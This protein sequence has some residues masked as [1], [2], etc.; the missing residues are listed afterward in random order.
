M[1]RPARDK[2][3]ELSVM[4]AQATPGARSR[5]RPPWPPPSRRVQDKLRH[6]D[7]ESGIFTARVGVASVQDLLE[8]SDGAPPMPHE[9]AMELLA[10]IAYPH[11]EG[12]TCDPCREFKK[13]QR[14]VEF[15]HTQVEQLVRPSQ[16]DVEEQAFIWCLFDALGDFEASKT[17]V[18]GSRPHPVQP[19]TIGALVQSLKCSRDVDLHTTM[20]E[21][22]DDGDGFVEFDNFLLWYKDATREEADKLASAELASRIKGLK[23][24]II[25]EEKSADTDELLMRIIDKFHSTAGDGAKDARLQALH[26]FVRTSYEDM[27]HPSFSRCNHNNDIEEWLRVEEGKQDRREAARRMRKR[28]AREEKRAAQREEQAKN[29]RDKLAGLERLTSSGAVTDMESQ[30]REQLERFAAGSE[31]VMC[32]PAPL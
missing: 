5:Q 11:G 10:G 24:A 22:D 19:D 14:Q 15:V 7:G 2:R 1:L 20:R 12:C 31:T 8:P 25:A 6:F 3:G 28:Q 26:K 30:I 23:N 16:H 18:E 21:I 4:R 17:G 9:E 27:E 32:A 13:H 29:E